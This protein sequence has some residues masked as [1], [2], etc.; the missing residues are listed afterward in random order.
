LLFTWWQGEAMDGRHLKSD[1]KQLL[2]AGPIRDKAAVKKALKV[3][4]KDGLVY[5]DHFSTSDRRKGPEQIGVGTKPLRIKKEYIPKDKVK[6]RTL[7]IELSQ[8]NATAYQ[9]SAKAVTLGDYHNF[10]NHGY[11]QLSSNVLHDHFCSKGLDVAMQ[12]GDTPYKIYGDNAMLGK[13]S[14]KMVKYSATTSHM[15]RDSI[16]DLAQTGATTI[17]T[18]TI[19]ARFPT[20]VRPVGIITNLSIEDWHGEGGSLHTLCTKKIFPDAAALFSKSSVAAKAVL[21][22]QVSKDAIPDVHTGAAF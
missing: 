12:Q 16:Y 1:S 9:K 6:F 11:L 7:M 19:A 8:G 14:A 4:I 13:E 21:A 15:S 20:Y 2:E 10:L 18:S 3:L 17:L 5:Y 22:T